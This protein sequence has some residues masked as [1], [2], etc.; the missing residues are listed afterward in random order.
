MRMYVG[1][2]QYV[3]L[4]S[5]FPWRIPRTFK[6]RESPPL[7]PQIPAV[8]HGALDPYTTS[9]AGTPFSSIFINSL[10]E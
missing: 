6:V 5:T 4:F 2:E 9:V 8:R 1:Q 3:I 7:Y 10:T